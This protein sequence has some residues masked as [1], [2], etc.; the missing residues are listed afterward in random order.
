MQVQY[1]AHRR[2]AELTRPETIVK[3]EPWYGREG[4]AGEIKTAVLIL[5]T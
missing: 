1:F 4:A 2:S 5:S 3:G